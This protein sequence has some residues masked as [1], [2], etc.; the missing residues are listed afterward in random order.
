MSLTCSQPSSDSKRKGSNLSDGNIPK[1]KG[2]HSSRPKLKILL[3]AF[4][5]PTEDDSSHV[6]IPRI[7]FAVTATPILAIPIQSIAQLPWVTNE[8]KEHFKSSPAEIRR[9]KLK[10]MINR[11][12]HGQDKLPLKVSE[13]STKK[14]IQLPL[15]MPRISW[16]SSMLNLTLLKRKRRCELQGEIGTR[17][18]AIRELVS[19]PLRVP[20]RGVSVFNVDAVIKEVDENAAS[21]FDRAY[22]TRYF[23]RLYAIIFQ[24]GVDAPPLQNKIEGLIKLVAKLK[25][26]EL[27]C[28]NLLTKLQLLEDQKKVLVRICFKRPSGKLLISRVR[29]TLLMPLK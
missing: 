27:R 8:I 20:Q 29:L 10:S 25:Q 19:R 7:G 14:V 18:S 21:V 11:T 16:I 1:D 9:E 26:V 22:S 17:S 12:I 15:E 23:D 3:E 5:P 13:P 2:I 6:K 24:T 28:D 4:I